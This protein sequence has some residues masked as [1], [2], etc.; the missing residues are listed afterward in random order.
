MVCSASVLPWTL[1]VYTE[2]SL[3]VRICSLSFGFRLKRK[4][5]AVQGA[6]CAGIPGVFVTGGIRFH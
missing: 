2:G 1:I 5:L 3:F 4:L 6:R